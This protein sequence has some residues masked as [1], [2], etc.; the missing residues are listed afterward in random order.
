MFLILAIS[1]LAEFLDSSLG[2]GYGTILSPILQL[3]GFASVEVVTSLLIA[4][5]LSG[6]LGGLGHIKAGNLKIKF[7]D[8]KK[9]SSMNSLIIL[10]STGIL[11]V[12]LGTVVRLEVN[13]TIL[14]ILMGSIILLTGIYILITRNRE[15]IF[16]KKKLFFLGA[17]A[18]FNK[19]FSGGGYG[20][21]VTSGQIASGCDT[22]SAIGITSLAEG[23]VSVLALILFWFSPLRDEFTGN[24]LPWV[25]LGSILSV[26]FSIVSVKKIQIR[27][28][29]LL[30][31][32]AS[33]LLGGLLIVKTLS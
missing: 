8:L 27:N 22:K 1:F 17:L 16:S 30:V 15:I 28:I 3:R 29:K 14:S 26:P 12:L 21:L 11:G 33:I 25:V 7:K 23:V 2:M 10:V 31:A 5:T 18:A 6:I 9:D 20:P 4:E 19:T 32:I 13:K 24:I